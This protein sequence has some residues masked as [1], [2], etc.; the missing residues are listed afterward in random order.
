VPGFGAIA[1]GGKWKVQYDS[2]VRMHHNT[3]YTLKKIGGKRGMG[4]DFKKAIDMLYKNKEQLLILGLTGRT[5]S[6]CST[7]ANILRRPYNELAFEFDKRNEYDGMDEYKFQIINDYMKEH[8]Q[9]VPFEVIEGSC[10]ILSYV[11]EQGH[12]NGDGLIEYINRLQEKTDYV[13]FRI[14]NDKKLQEDIKGLGY[15]FK[16][17]QELSLEKKN[18]G[19]ESC[20]DEEIEKYYELYIKQL[21][22]YKNRIKDIL[23]QYSCYEIETR[24]LEDKKPVRYHLYTYLLQKMGNNIRSSGN[25]YN[26]KFDPD[27]IL[28]LAKRLSLLIELIICRNDR[29]GQKS[30]IC[31]DA[32]RNENESNYLKDKFKPYYLLA[33]SVDEETRR[34]RLQ[35]L[36]V[37]EK[38]GIDNIEYLGN[39]K[40]ERYFYQQNIA[41]CI[42]MADIHIY[43]EE[44]SQPQ[45]F[46]LTWQLVKY[47]TLMIHPGLITPTCLERCMQLAYTAKFN[48]GCLSRQVGAIVTDGDFSVK[49]VGW[50]DVPHGQ[51]PCN[52]RNIE[53]YMKGNHSECFRQ[54]VMTSDL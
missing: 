13:Q 28:T 26:D 50:N 30:R 21:P 15:C 47:I 5:G 39:Y 10:V 14:S 18:K 33:I 19:W 44:V 53:L 2:G 3:N 11:F 1:G 51:M 6:G 9:W 45:K 7:V 16:E 8:G 36:D 25:P 32:I 54:Y 42:E 24:K 23:S 40:A 17:V 46:F 12:E 29:K 52:L 49:A 34:K 31:I 48:S 20:S 38:N 22:K 43:N 35:D 41:Q 27:Q 37:M 4:N